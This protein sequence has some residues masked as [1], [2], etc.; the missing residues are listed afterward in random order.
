MILQ[1][2]VCTRQ[3]LQ[4]NGILN[5]VVPFGKLINLGGGLVINYKVLF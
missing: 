3:Y 5:K 2:A 4:P 1:S